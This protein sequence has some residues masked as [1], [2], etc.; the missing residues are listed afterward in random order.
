MGRK[1]VLTQVSDASF[2]HQQQPVKHG[3]YFG[4]GLV[5]GAEDGFPPSC[6][7]AQD[8]DHILRHER[9]QTRRRLV[10]EHQGR[11]RED[12]RRE[13]QTFHFST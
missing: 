7:I 1:K 5:N 10:A 8:T 12:F 9:V 6:H 4:R 13:R 3:K 11:I 2:W